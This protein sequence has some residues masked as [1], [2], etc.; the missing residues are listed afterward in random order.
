MLKLSILVL[1][2]FEGYNNFDFMRFLSV[3]ERGGV[4][5]TEWQ[6]NVLLSAL[7]TDLNADRYWGGKP[8]YEMVK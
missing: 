1:G 6:Q 4:Y 8:C 2:A 7:T 5:L 3:L